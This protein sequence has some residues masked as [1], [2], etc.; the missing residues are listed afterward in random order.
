MEGPEGLRV[1]IHN[2]SASLP[3]S[4]TERN[5]LLQAEGIAGRARSRRIAG[6]AVLFAESKQIAGMILE[7]RGNV[8][9]VKATGTNAAA[10]LDQVLSSMRF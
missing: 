1:E 5:K 7:N 8:W 3:T 9:V 4:S 2:E 10:L 6:H